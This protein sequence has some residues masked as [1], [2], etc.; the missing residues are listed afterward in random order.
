[1]LRLATLVLALSAVLGSRAD[2]QPPPDLVFDG[3]QQLYAGDIDASH[4]RFSALRGDSRQ[5]P[6]WFGQLFAGLAQVEH[7]E[8]LA[9]A[10]ERDLDAFI[11]EA[12]GRYARS[13]D[14]AEALFYLAHVHMLR[15]TYRISHDKGMLSAARDA[16]RAKGYAEDYVRVHPEHG[17][18]YLTLGLYNYYAG[19]APTFVKVLRVLLFLPGGNRTEGLAQIEKAAREGGLFAPVAQGLLG[20]LYGTIEG[21]LPDALTTG[22]RLAARY[23]RNALVRLWLAQIYAHPTVEAYS[24]AE[25]EYRAVLQTATSASARH[26]SERHRAIQ[27][28]AALRRSQWRLDEAVQLLTP[29]IDQRIRRPAWVYPTLLL[30]RASYRML[31]NDPGAADDARRVAADPEL[32]KWRNE[33]RELSREIDAWRHRPAEAALYVQLIPGNRLVAED[34]WEEA[35]AFYDRLAAAHP[36]DWQIRFRLAAL[37]FAR[38]EYGAAAAGLEAIVSTRERLPDWLRAN[39]LLTLAWTRDLAGRRADAL[40][41][42]R[43]VVDSYED[44]SAAGPARIGLLTPYRGPVKR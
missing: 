42:Y 35:R 26:V 32:R 11:A 41:L 30:Q 33:A 22:E 36:G 28:M 29:A 14:D 1:M 5:L 16:A 25:A 13:R 8:T 37:E 38:G 4:Q 10:F 43:R 6:A 17:D 39:A 9:P 20:I 15:G 31:L 19:I 2:A 27:G 23:P 7:D 12:E 3:Y 44:E 21:R 18:A 34:R 40:A 24:R